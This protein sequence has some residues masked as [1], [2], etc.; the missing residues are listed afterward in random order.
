MAPSS[1]VPTIPRLLPLLRPHSSEGGEKARATWAS[2]AVFSWASK[3]YVCFGPRVD[4]EIGVRNGRF[5]LARFD[6]IK[7]SETYRISSNWVRKMGGSSKTIFLLLTVSTLTCSWGRQFLSRWCNVS[8]LVAENQSSEGCRSLPRQGV[9]NG[10]ILPL[11]KTGLGPG[12]CF[13][14]GLSSSI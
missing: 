1:S 5:P 6:V 3:Y 14:R 2:Y 7:V 12:P 8:A 11:T 4:I 13:P 10:M 9:G